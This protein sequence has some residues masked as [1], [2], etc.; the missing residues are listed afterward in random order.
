MK[1]EDRVAIITG[2]G[3]GIGL[4]IAIEMARTG[5][6]VVT[7][8]RSMEHLNK[9]VAQ[10]TALGRQCLA[11]A[12]DVSKAEDVD[13][14][15]HKTMER[16]GR[17]DILVNNAGG[18]ARERRALFHQSAEEVWDYVIGI[19][20]KGV[21]NCTRAVINHMIDRRSGKI[22]NIASISGMI[23]TAGA[24]E[25]STAKA[26]VIGFTK[27]LAK[28]VVSYGINVNC[29]SPDYIE[30]GA[31]SFMDDARRESLKKMTGFDEPG[32]PKDVA[33]MVLFLVSD[34]ASFI[35]GQNFVVGGLHN[36]G[37]P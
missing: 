4:A 27:A 19:N 6:N 24:V 33:K 32:K 12:T 14:M 22:V 5:A 11:V 35:T 28:E 15:V 13:S 1:L 20:L 37:R 26:G 36:L 25:Y 18:S 3:T 17:I 8:S 31:H 9:A 10:V 23:G 29:V 21:R 34:E 16:F 30:S 7:A 2:G